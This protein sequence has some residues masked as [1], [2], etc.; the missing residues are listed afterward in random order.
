MPSLVGDYAE[1]RAE[2]T[3]LT[4]LLASTA[5]LGPKHRKYIAEVALLRLAILIENS[6]KAIFCKLSC[7][8][9]YI[10][11]SAPTLLAQQRNTPAAISAMQNHGRAKFRYGLPWND[12][13]EIRENIRF[14]IDPADRCHA[15]LITHA[16]FLTDIRY[17]RNHI[18]HRNDNSRTNFVKLVRRYYGAKVPGVT[19]GNLLVSPRVSPDRP[20]LETYIITANVMMKDI[21][22]G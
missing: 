11:G 16:S 2:T 19:C 18:A 14:L 22:R 1:F 8:A 13:G 21:V 7:G 12:G 10:D 6:L 17:I 3:R 4:A 9:N 5:E 20:L 15:D